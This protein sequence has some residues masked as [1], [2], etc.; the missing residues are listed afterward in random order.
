MQV[1]AVHF[2]RGWWW[3]CWWWWW[4]GVG[5]AF[6]RI[7]SITTA[8]YF[9]IISKLSGL[10]AVW[11]CE[12]KQLEDEGRKMKRDSGNKAIIQKKKV[13][14]ELERG[15]CL[16]EGWRYMVLKRNIAAQSLICNLKTPP[17]QQIKSSGLVIFWSACGLASESCVNL[18]WK[19]KHSRALMLVL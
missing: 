17:G 16:V 3:C 12:V 6:A 8:Y 1:M 18:F 9:M 15:K 10:T 2:W 4:W 19:T 13:W 14:I 5:S 7:F 11:N